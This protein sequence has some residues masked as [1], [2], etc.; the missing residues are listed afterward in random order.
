[1]PSDTLL[2]RVIAPYGT[3]VLLFVGAGFISGGIVHLGEGWN[4]WDASLLVLGVACF[5]VGSYVQEVLYHKKRLQE[6]GVVRFL[7]YSLLLS[8]GVGMASGGTQH[9]IDTPRYSMYLIPLGLLLGAGAFV[10]KQ[11]IS[12]EKREWRRLMI[13]GLVF[14]ALLWLGL[15]VIASDAPHSAGHSHGSRSSMHVSRGHADHASSVTDERSFLEQMIPHHQEAVETSAYVLTRTSNADL[16]GF[17]EGVIT[18]QTEEITLMRGWYRSWYGREYVDD[19][20]YAPMMGDLTRVSGNELDQ[21]YIQGMIE[22]H[23][24]AVQMAERVL[25][26][27]TKNEIRTMAEAIIRV[28]NAEIQQLQ[29]WMQ[30]GDTSHQHAH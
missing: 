12:L 6:E 20:S 7:A 15:S 17:L 13:G 21:A 29:G 24:G 22:H 16:E 9:F 18:A 30:G 5:I 1:M 10:G 11:N 14:G 26:L 27:S 25:A 2:T 4:L 8:I 3:F 19:G 23:R 28:Q